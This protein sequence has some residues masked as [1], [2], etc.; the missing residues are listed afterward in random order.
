MLGYD[1]HCSYI[2]NCVGKKN[3]KIFL[4]F[5]IFITLFLFS[6]LTLN[7]LASIGQLCWNKPSL[8]FALGE[9]SV[10]GGLRAVSAYS[11][12]PR[13]RYDYSILSSFGKALK[14]SYEESGM[15]YI[16]LVV[17]NW[18]HLAFN[19]VSAVLVSLLLK[20][21]LKNVCQGT[22]TY[23]RHL[24]KL[25]KKDTTLKRELQENFLKT[26]EGKKSIL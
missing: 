6:R 5:L 11:E 25:A 21:T 7:F 10:A 26:S 8:Q 13:C 4:F 24:K 14:E 20:I 23:E 9:S 22:T 19:L 16:V 12:E 3:I 2:L 18:F 15:L 1:H 17:V